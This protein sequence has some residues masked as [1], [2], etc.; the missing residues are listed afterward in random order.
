MF[1]AENILKR[2]DAEEREALLDCLLAMA[3]PRQEVAPKLV[4]LAE[5]VEAAKELQAEDGELVGLSSGWHS[6]DQL[7]GG[8]RGSQ[9]IV[10]FGETGHRKSMFVQNL[11]YNVATAGHPVLFIGLEMANEENTERF[12]DMGADGTLPI[13][14]PESSTVDYKDIDG[15]V[16]T[17]AAGGVELVVVDHL[18]MFSLDGENEQAGLTK[19]CIEMKKISRRY[20]AAVILVSHISRQRDR[21]GIPTLNDLKGSSSIGQLADKAI[22]VYSD[23]VENDMPDDELTLMLRKSR[24]L[25]KQKLAKLTILPNAKLVEPAWVG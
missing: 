2:Y 19:I 18:H 25:A 24:R 7:L 5:T 9:L 10:V 3:E 20:G 14:Y 1:K 11:A 15:L 23:G 21:K 8:I 13:V 4:H 6:V 12:L 16:K 22:A 17:A